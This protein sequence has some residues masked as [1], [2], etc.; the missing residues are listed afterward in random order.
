MNGLSI[1]PV[2]LLKMAS[3]TRALSDSALADVARSCVLRRLQRGQLLFS[4]G[5]P[6]ESFYLVRSGSMRVLRYSDEGAE[7][8]LSVIGPGGAIGELSVFDGASRSA[9]VEAVER[10]EVLGIPN[11]RI[12]EAL[13]TSPESLIAVVADLAS[14]VRRLTGSTVDLVFLDVPRRV[15]KFLLLN[16]VDHGDGTGHV[17]F[18]MSQSGIASQLGVARQTFNQALGDLARQDLIAIE[19]KRIELLDTASLQEFLG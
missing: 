11:A 10:C 7:Y 19:G 16:G 17:D 2:A 15:A 18:A 3:I 6:S 5:D 9:S 4:E 14:T 1:D 8:V 12:R 13:K